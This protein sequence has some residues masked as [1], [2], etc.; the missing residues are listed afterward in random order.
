PLEVETLPK[1][2]P[3]AKAVPASLRARPEGPTVVVLD[4]DD[5]WAN[6]TLKGHSVVVLNA[7]AGDAEQMAALAP[8]RAVGNLAAPG[9]L[10][11]VTAL[12]AAGCRSRFWGCIGARG[13]K[14]ALPLGMVEPGARPLEAEAV[15]A[16]LGALASRG[17]RVVTTGGDVD[18]LMSLRQAI[19]RQGMSVSMAWDAKQAADLLVMVKPQVV[20]I[21]LESPREGYSV[22]AALSAADPIPHAL[23]IPGSSGD[24]AAGFLPV[25]SDPHHAERFAPLDRI[26]QNA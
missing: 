2:A 22:V 21:D 4:V 18:A 26:L 14:R 17:T 12:R 8:E 15:L 24:G 9:A 16:A 5:T 3:P 25:L 11:T 7:E 6:V 10:A 20:V 23:L 19:A 1:S 13:T